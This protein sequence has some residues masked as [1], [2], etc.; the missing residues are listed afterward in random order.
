MGS[1][2]PII[3]GVLGREQR[4]AGL[5]A[6]GLAHMLIGQSNEIAAAMPAG[7]SH[8]LEAKSRLHEDLAS[9]ASLERRTYEARGPTFSAAMARGDTAGSGARWAC[10]VLPLLALTGLLWYLLA[11]DRETAVPV[12]TS[13]SASEPTEAVQTKSAF[14]STAPDGWTSI[15]SAPNEYGNK[16]VYTRTSDRLGTIVESSLGRTAA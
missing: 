16:E 13:K 2:A 12:A 1:L 11:G 9:P 14:L 10:W 6:N 15:G 4:A 8:L 5:D 3:M 7:L